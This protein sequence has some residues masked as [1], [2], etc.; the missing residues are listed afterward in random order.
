MHSLIY[1]IN[2]FLNNWWLKRW[3]FTCNHGSI[4]LVYIIAGTIGGSIGTA[5]S[6]LMRAEL[7]I[8]GYVLVQDNLHDYNVW[9]TAHGILM[10]F[11]MVMPFMIGGLGNIIVPIQIGSPD[12]V[13][14]RFNNLSF[15]LLPFSMVFLMMS[16]FIENGCGVGWTLYAPL[17]GRIGNPGNSVDLVIFSVHF[18]GMSSILG[19]I[20]FI[21]TIGRMRWTIEPFDYWTKL[22]LYTWSIWV[23]GWLLVISVPVL[24]AAITMLLFDRHL[25]T[26]FYDPYGG[27]D[28]LLFQHLFWFFGHPEV[29]ILIFPGFGIMSEVI[30]KYS[31]TPI[32]GKEGMIYATLGI[33]FLGLIVWGHH[34]YTVG[35]DVDTRAYFTAGTSVIGIPTG[36]KIFSW[37]ATLW[38]GSYT[39]GIPILFAAG[40][41]F[42]FTFGG[43]TGLLLASAALDIS[44][45]DS[46]FVVGHFH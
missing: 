45:H 38:T 35:L 15:W 23:T 11:F 7:S 17:S 10:I 44:F 21:G 34:M 40:F 36:I 9:I 43:I 8:P 12:M 14:P 28:P 46:Y 42:L 31:N 19:A 32:F 6:F 39:P 3:V 2:S 5:F 22:P 1:R 26:S 4:G 18:A 27:G 37:F 24:A 33:S 29:Y 20:N 30:S 13:F 16:M 25:N 41:L